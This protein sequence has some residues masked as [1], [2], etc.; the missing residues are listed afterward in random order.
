MKAILEFDVPRSCNSCPTRNIFD[1]GRC[2]WA[3]A[4][5]RNHKDSRHPDCPLIIK[6]VC[7]TC[8][9]KDS[10]DY[11]GNSVVECECWETKEGTE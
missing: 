10:C 4:F 7:A 8:D 3:R 11:S 5:V 9:K 6:G 1:D 2:Y